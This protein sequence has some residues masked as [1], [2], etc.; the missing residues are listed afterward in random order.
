[1]SAPP[2]TPESLLACAVDVARA[3]GAH[4]MANLDR[5]RVSIHE[6]QHDVK[7]ELDVE[8]QKIA[9][10]IIRERYPDHAFLGEEDTGAT[11]GGTGDFQWIVDPI[12][13]TVN[14]SS[15][16]PFWCCSVAVRRG[17][18]TLAGAVYAPELDQLY[19]AAANVPA[20]L[21]GNTL[22]VSSTASLAESI[23][24]TGMDKNVIP[25]MPRYA[26][27]RTVADHARKARIL[28]SAALDLCRVAVGQADG[29]VE[30]GIYLWDMAAA[31]LIVQRAGGAL[32]ILRT[33]ENGRLV[34]VATN[35][36]IQSE[37]VK[38]VA[39][40]LPPLQVEA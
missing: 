26:V 28:G 13:G 31:G 19:T 18:D 3:A 33:L 11:A 23:V 8:C 24:M 40:V 39:A 4:A 27:F 1:M 5:R 32:E 14:F 35:G 25:E 15:G 12:D 17:P 34:C 7:L 22:S 37:L 29:Y 30:A 21:N 36:R 10:G 2:P 9:E 38:R 6:S 20:Q 16:F